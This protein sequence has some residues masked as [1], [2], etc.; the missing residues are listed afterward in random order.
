M[1]SEAEV[2]IGGLEAVF[3][4]GCMVYLK[5]AGDVEHLEEVQLQL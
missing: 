2:E 5:Y 1:R 3:C 4:L